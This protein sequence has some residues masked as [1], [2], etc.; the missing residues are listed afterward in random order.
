MNVINSFIISLIEKD[1]TSLNISSAS[2]VYASFS[3]L[4]SPKP[5]CSALISEL[6]KARCCSMTLEY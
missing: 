1:F 4:P 6:G 3:L 5:S 2:L